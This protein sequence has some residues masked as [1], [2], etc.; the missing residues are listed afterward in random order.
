MKLYAEMQRGTERFVFECPFPKKHIAEDAGFRRDSDSFR[1]FTTDPAIAARLRSYA[2]GQLR[3][4]LNAIAAESAT[5]PTLR[6]ERGLYVF[7]GEREHTELAR[8]ADFFRDPDTGA[9]Y[10]PDPQYA[11]Q[12]AA[13]GDDSC[14]A[15]IRASL[16]ALDEMFEASRALDADIE[17]PAPEGRNYFPHQ[18]AAVAYAKR[19]LRIGDSSLNGDA[20]PGMLLGDAMRVGKTPSSIGVINLGGDLFSKILVVCPAG[21]KLG[22]YR[23]LNSWL[24]AKRKI[25]IADSATSAWKFE[26]AEISIV[27]FDVLKGL[28]EWERRAS[29]DKRAV[30]RS[31]G[32][33]DLDWDLVIVDEA[34]MISNPAALRSIV[35]YALLERAT[36]K[37]ALT[38][39]PITNWIEGL[40]ALLHA[41][42]PASW[43]TLNR[44]KARY[45]SGRDARNLGD[46]KR[47]LR[48]TI[49]CR[50]LLSEVQPNLPP[51]VREVL[52]FSA[53]DAAAMRAVQ[54]EAAAWERQQSQL[55][56]LQAAAELAKASDDQKAHAEASKLLGQGRRI[57][58]TET[59]KLRHETAL[60]K[61]PYVVDH[62][63]SLIDDPAYKV[64]VGAWHTDV[65]EKLAAPFGKKAV[66]V[67]GEVSA[68]LKAVG[69]IET[70][71]RMQRV[72]RF[73]EDPT[74]Q[75]FFGNLVAAGMGLNL[76]AASHIIC[77]ELWYVPWVMQQF[78]ARC[79][80]PTKSSSIFVQHLVL[81]GSIDAR[82]AWALLEKQALIDR[83]LDGI[84]KEEEVSLI[85]EPATKSLTRAAIA[86]EAEELTVKQI[87]DVHRGLKELSGIN[88]VDV[89]I[90]RTLAS[91]SMLTA[92]QAVIGDAILRRYTNEIRS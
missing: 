8:N 60:V 45:G 67:T 14:H 58:F 87:R 26:V 32:R 70:S 63:K 37:L 86:R 62:V 2:T 88:E 65:I 71:D 57:A 6:F 77:A 51:K 79:E 54:R 83:A 47:K 19:V 10:T 39:T 13:Y 9:W 38:G 50:R 7:R 35:G 5:K 92:K 55:I 34:H 27:N 85:D 48:S 1:W 42:D 81:A 52:E 78:E 36:R 69:G 20:L 24:T 56:I 80:H 29:R 59:A 25:L 41:L 53:E 11:K 89:A 22:W 30:L 73:L 90:A 72:D 46:L 17:I 28:A 23:E 84:G 43:P 66:T 74:C 33:L 16:S 18:R 49:M 61:V 44:F 31:L 64:V 82:I 76:S 12:L 91:Y 4:R 68:N 21:V 40:F 3:Q 15:Q 75:I